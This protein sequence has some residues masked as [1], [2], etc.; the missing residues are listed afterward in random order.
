[1]GVA[2]KSM[3]RTFR[4]MSCVIGSPSAAAAAHVAT[5]THASSAA[6]A[7]V[8]ATST[9]TGH[10]R[11]ATA[12][13]TVLRHRLTARV[14]ST[15]LLAGLAASVARASQCVVAA[16]RI[17][18]GQPLIGSGSAASGSPRAPCAGPVTTRAGSSILR[19]LACGRII[20]KLVATLPRVHAALLQLRL[21]LL[22][23]RVA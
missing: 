10:V 15:R 4:L 14:A 23:L 16:T 17:D 21:R 20:A 1:M 5:T 9:A 19:T 3:V 8:G 11:R 13:P 12:A 22:A 6:A 18:A 2:W 7:H